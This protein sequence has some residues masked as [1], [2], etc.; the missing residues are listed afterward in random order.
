MKSITTKE[1]EVK[2]KTVF[3]AS[4][5]LLFD[6]TNVLVKKENSDFDVTQG[7]YDGAKV[8]ELV[9]LYLL[10]LLTNDGVSLY[11]DDGLS[12]F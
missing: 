4:K 2:K 5:S 6:K 3:H 8:C 12:C 9:G 1:A 10:N 7:S 11:G